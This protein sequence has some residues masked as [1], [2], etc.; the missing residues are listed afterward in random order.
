MIALLAE[1]SKITEAYCVE[2]NLPCKR[3]YTQE[4]LAEAL[5]AVRAAH[6]ALYGQPVPAEACTEVVATPTG[7][8]G[9]FDEAVERN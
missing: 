4:E 9:A 8:L 2:H 1:V 7:T 5:Q 3:F 6:A